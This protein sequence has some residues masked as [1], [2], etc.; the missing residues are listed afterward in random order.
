MDFPIRRIFERRTYGWYTDRDTLGLHTMP[1]AFVILMWKLMY[2]ANSVYTILWRQSPY[3]DIFRCRWKIWNRRW[4]RQRWKVGL[5]WWKYPTSLLWWLT[6]RT[7]QWALRVCWRLCVNMS[8][9]DLSACLGAAETAVKSAVM[10][11]ERCP[12]DWPTL[13]LLPQ[14]IQGT[15]NLRRL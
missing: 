14:T 9:E 1:Q 10:K 2:Q 15:R 12:A 13:P 8:P 11:W 7:M 6:M 5:K 3:A 4:D